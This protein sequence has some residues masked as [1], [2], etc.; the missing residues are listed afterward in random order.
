MIG[1]ELIFNTSA[2]V[3]MTNDVQTS[4]ARM[5]AY[6]QAEILPAL[7]PAINDALN[8]PPGPVKR[9]FEFATARSQ[10][11]FFANRKGGY[12]RTGAVLV[13]RGGL[14]IDGATG[15]I[16]A[17]NPVSYSRYLY[18]PNQVRG[19]FNTG[20]PNKEQRV[21]VLQPPALQLVR[22]GWIIV[23]AGTSFAKAA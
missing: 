6:V 2:V 15:T 1:V 20:W 4:T 5:H 8:R 22:A 11:W 23:S 12:R 18:G 7:Q 21:L 19:H 13:W 16:L 17:V 14:D 3:G 9:P 10:R